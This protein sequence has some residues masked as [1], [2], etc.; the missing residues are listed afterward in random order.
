M[1]E[2]LKNSDFQSN[3]LAGLIFFVAELALVVTL[4]PMFIQRRLDL[5][6][7]P[8]RKKLWEE[9]DK[10]IVA[11][12]NVLSESVGRLNTKTI[13]VDDVLSEVRSFN[14]RLSDVVPV[15]AMALDPKLMEL[16]GEVKTKTAYLISILERRVRDSAAGGTTD[17]SAYY[18]T[19]KFKGLAET[20]DEMRA[21]I[22]SKDF[23][24]TGELQPEWVESRTAM[25]SS[26]RDM[27]LGA[28][29]KSG[30]IR[31]TETKK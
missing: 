22:V 29:S 8:A 31:G 26:R 4:L 25:F 28:L 10:E 7:Q 27:L 30:K 2:L 24:G 21:Y 12:A 18:D 17:G 3:L 16:C 19:A 1:L 6:W 14:R 20:L 15:Y 23:F 9:L 5:R 13:D 11:L